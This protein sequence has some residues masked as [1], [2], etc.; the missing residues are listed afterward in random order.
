MCVDDRYGWN[1][2]NNNGNITGST[3]G[4]HVAGIAAAQGDNGFGVAGVSWDSEFV[5]ISGSSGSTS[6]VL[7]AY[8]YA[9]DLK[10][11]WIASGGVE[12]ANIVAT[13]SSFGID[14]ANCNS[15]QYSPWNDMY[16]LMG[17]SGI[18]SCAATANA[19]FNIDVV[20]DVPTG[21]SSDFVVSVTATNN[22]D[23]R[24][25]SAYGATTIDLG[26]PGESIFSTVTG[27]GFGSSVGAIAMALGASTTDACTPTITTA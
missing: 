2:Y 20:G 6:T 10:D 23:Q 8:G 26:A 13:N 11:D 1:A 14:L 19:Q 27:N 24:T 12:G 15:P 4:T 9:L 5:S 18:L 25:F 21:C 3:H 16:D 22:R 7:I 17:Q